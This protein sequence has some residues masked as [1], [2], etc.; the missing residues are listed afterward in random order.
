MFTIST[1]KTTS[2]ARD[3]EL[4]IPPDAP[5]TMAMT[6]WNVFSL[7]YEVL[8]QVKLANHKSLVD[9]RYPIIVCSEK[10]PERPIK[11]GFKNHVFKRA[12]DID[13]ASDDDDDYDSEEEEVIS[14]R[15]HSVDIEKLEIISGTEGRGLEG[16][17]AQVTFVVNS[18]VARPLR[19]LRLILS[20]ELR[21]GATWYE[22]LRFKALA[23]SD[24]YSQFS[25][26]EHTIRF[27]LPFSESQYDVNILAP[28]L[29]DD[30]RYICRA[31]TVSWRKNNVSAEVD[32]L[33]DRF[34]DTWAKEAFKTDHVEQRGARGKYIFAHVE[35][36][37]KKLSLQ[38]IQIRRLRVPG[39]HS[40]DSYV[41]E[42]IVVNQECHVEEIEMFVEGFLP[43]PHNIP[44]SIEI[45]YWN[46][47]I[48][49]Y[50]LN[51]VTTLEDG[52][53]HQHRIPIWIGCTDDNL[54]P[55]KKRTRLAPTEEPR[56]ES[57]E[58]GE[59]PEFEVHHPEETRYQPYWVERFNDHT[60][61]YMS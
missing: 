29:G 2:T 51:V 38:L 1:V 24:N 12:I 31:S 56:R 14:T 13:D 43:I 44:P 60:Y 35:G 52:H 5:I 30:I 32:I 34:V 41:H 8:L 42:R 19:G 45:S 15:I 33:V 39:I 40:D 11:K 21:A 3:C 61:G 22:F 46:V 37:Q 23:S 18:N 28:S 49:S 47:L 50:E 16:A 53:T 9:F 20:G 54:G 27:S 6:L 26:G 58:L 36:R 17:S 55:P 4:E 57:P 59:L 10:V 48:I 7:E 25:P